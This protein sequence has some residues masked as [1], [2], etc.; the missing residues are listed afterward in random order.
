MPSSLVPG[1]ARYGARLGAMAFSDDGRFLAVAVDDDAVQLWD[2]GARLPLGEPLT[3]TGQRID[4]LSFDGTTL[5]TVTGDR[6]Q[7]LDLAP[8]KL[9]ATVCR[10][11]GRDIT[12]QEWRTYVPDAPH[13]SL[14]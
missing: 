5:R 12:A 6:R 10:R 9:A 11:V 1:G 14:C 2:T 4:T 3:L 13:R 7:A 8:E